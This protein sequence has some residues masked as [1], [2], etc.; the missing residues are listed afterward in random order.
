MPANGKL[1]V[2]STFAWG[3]NDRLVG[4]DGTLIL[5]TR[6]DSYTQTGVVNLA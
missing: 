6:T 2:G 5:S 3:P 1:G 4:R